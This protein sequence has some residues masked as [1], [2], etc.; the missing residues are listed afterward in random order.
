M[1]SS[2]SDALR[3]H[4]LVV[5]PD[6][7]SAEFLI[8]DDD[9]IAEYTKLRDGPTEGDVY[10]GEVVDVRP[11]LK[12]AFVDIGESHHALVKV[13]LRPVSELSPGDRLVCQLTGLP[14]EGKGFKARDRLIPDGY[15]VSI[16]KGSS[17]RGS[18]ICTT[19]WCRSDVGRLGSELVRRC[20]EREVGLV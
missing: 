11:G 7:A 20:E 18:R 6:R 13:G 8:I 4:E 1:S 5:R 14:R 10:L 15:Y 17:I 19:M 12:S 9:G 16:E 2:N 3:T